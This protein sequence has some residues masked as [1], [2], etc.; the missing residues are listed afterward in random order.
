MNFYCI[1]DLKAN[2]YLTPFTAMNHH[3][4][5]RMFTAS[6]SDPNTSLYQFPTDYELF[7][8]GTFCEQTARMDSDDKMSLGLAA[9][10]RR[11]DFYP[12]QPQPTT[13]DGTGE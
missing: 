7:Y 11:L 5:K 13:F 6:C 10:F 12:P 4:A 2:Y 8:I 9:S 1:Y 3:V